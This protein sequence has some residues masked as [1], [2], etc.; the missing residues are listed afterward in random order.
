VKH[1]RVLV[2]LVVAGAIAATA[3][4]AAVAQEPS[5]DAYWGQF[6]SFFARFDNPEFRNYGE[7][8]SGFAK[9]PGPLGTTVV[10]FFK[11]IAC[12]EG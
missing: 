6:V 4:S 3:P 8:V 11:A 2:P 7:V 9:L 12:G 5:E 10:P 1:R